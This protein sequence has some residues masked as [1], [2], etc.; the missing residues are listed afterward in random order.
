MLLDRKVTKFMAFD[1]YKV[2]KFLDNIRIFL[3]LHA[4]VT[5]FR[6][7]L[8]STIIKVEI[9]TSKQVNANPGLQL[10]MRVKIFYT[11]TSPKQ[12][13][14]ATTIQFFATITWENSG[15]FML[16]CMQE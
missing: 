6:S 15:F 10:P 16:T 8:T 4:Q 7:E 14:S 12:A 9:E 3:K 5:D 13:I 2:D 1:Q 11:T